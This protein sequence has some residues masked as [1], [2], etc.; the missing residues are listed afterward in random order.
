MESSEQRRHD[1]AFRV[2]VRTNARAVRSIIGRREHDRMEVDEIS[3]DVFALAYARMDTLGA[4]SE[5]EVR[6]WLFRTARFLTAN[7]VRRSMSRRRLY[8]R[9][10][11]EPLPLSAAPDD[12]LAAW[13][14]EVVAQQQSARISVAL[15][16]LRPDYRRALVMDALGHKGRDI[17]SAMAISPNAARKRL[18]RARAA[19][20]LSYL[21]ATS[22][23]VDNACEGGSQ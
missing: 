4:V 21:E 20:R 22:N 1:E 6:S 8:E 7:E 11:R 5:G 13:D 16:D 2:L 18:M 23:D 19:F 12:E 3:A 17:G 15:A 14:D 9:L 10:Q